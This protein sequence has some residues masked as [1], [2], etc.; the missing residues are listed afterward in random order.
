MTDFKSFTKTFKDG[1]VKLVKNAEKDITNAA[2]DPDNAISHENQAGD[3]T[4]LVALIRIR[5]PVR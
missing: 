3:H 4:S 2:T 5:S 1:V